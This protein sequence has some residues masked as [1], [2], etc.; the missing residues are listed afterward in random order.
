MLKGIIPTQTI[1][2]KNK[3]NSIL[4]TYNPIHF[5]ICLKESNRRNVISEKVYVYNTE[6]RMDDLVAI[7]T[8]YNFGY[9]FYIS[10]NIQVSGGELYHTHRANL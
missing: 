2:I 7:D 4:K 5:Y 3:F 8:S 1:V 10:G 9:F 6:L